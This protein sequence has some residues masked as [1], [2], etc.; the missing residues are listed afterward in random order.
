MRTTIVIAAVTLCGA[1]AAA[2]DLFS[3]TVTEIGNPGNTLTAGD[4]VLPD[5]VESLADTSGAFSSFSTIDF[6]ATLSYAGV[7]NAMEITYLQTGGVFGGEV[8]II[9][10]LLGSDGPIV[11]D[12]ANGDLGDQLEDFF[13]EDDPERIGKFLE[14]IAKQSLVA[15]TDGNPLATTAR[16]AQYKFDRFGLFADAGPTTWQL[17]WMDEN[18]RPVVPGEGAETAPDAP[19]ATVSINEPERFRARVD[20]AGYTTEA[21]GFEGSSFDVAYSA[22]LRLDNRLSVVLGVPISYHEV[23]GADV[24]NIGFHLDAPITLASPAFDKKRGFTWQITPGIGTDIS[25]SFDF[26]AGGVLYTWALNNR[27][28]YDLERWSFTTAQQFSFHESEEIEFDDSRF[29]PNVSQQ[30]LKLGGK[31]SYRVSDNLFVYGGA[32][33][34]KFIQD[35]AVDDYTTPMAGFGLRSSGGSTITVGWQADYGGDFERQGARL[36]VDVPF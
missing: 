30:I 16:S 17:S 31:V 33:W 5:L 1:Q 34:T 6:N 18:R 28:T 12:S 27:L 3:V 25:G 36:L 11:F 21:D 7:A 10:N 20:V 9:D 26:A 23:E 13:L 8:L 35:V 2:Q 14:E 22:E 4:S 19:P 32:T 29:D 24:F 15:V